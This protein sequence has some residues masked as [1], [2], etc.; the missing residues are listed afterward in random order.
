M[1]K[2]LWAILWIA[3]STN[4]PAPLFTFYQQNYQLN[5]LAI[6]TLFAIYAASLLPFLLISSSLADL[7]G[8]RWTNTLGLFLAFLSALL[9]YFSSQFWMLYIARVLEGI[10]VGVFM[11]TSNAL[12]LTNVKNEAGEISTAL[13]YSSMS[14]MFG[15][16]CGPMLCGLVV[17]YSPVIPLQLPYLLLLVGLGSALGLMFTIKE[18][19]PKLR[20]N[21]HFHINL[22][23]S[24]E[25]KRI[26]WYF[27]APAAFSM[28][29]LNG[30][31]ISLIPKYTKVL[32]HSQN[33]AFS[34]FLLF[35]MLS[36]SGIAQ[37]IPWPQRK[38][39]RVQIGI[40]SII[41]GTWLMIDAAPTQSMST[42]FWGMI[43]Q[44]IGTGWTFQESLQL[45]GEISTPQNRSRI[46]STFFVCAY[47]GMAFPTIGIGW[48]STLWGLMPALCS[49]GLVISLV[50]I[51]I[52]CG[53]F[54]FDTPLES[55]N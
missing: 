4:L 44:A 14:N 19:K 47:T 17:Q 52:I 55:S 27:I 50:G 24:A 21:I 35:L 23:V 15:F 13:K 12:L 2:I 39:S 26:F 31:V 18:N 54:L 41:I 32:F 7:K 38:I 33:F 29:A 5:D 49:F 8:L 34:G 16:G 10:A 46:M 42:L 22:G 25:S 1:K 37:L 20:Q 40:L 43:F 11:G 9:F 48:L 45:V 28:L 51:G 3:I 6:T 53:P 30:I 36:G